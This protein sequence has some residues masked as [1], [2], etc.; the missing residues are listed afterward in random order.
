ML[1]CGSTHLTNLKKICSRQKHAIRIVFNKTKFKHI[2]ELFKLINV[3][4]LHKFINIYKYIN[5]LRN[6]VFMHRVNTETSPTV[7][8]RRVQKIYHLYSTTRFFFQY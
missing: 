2:K 1:L 5:I 3:L 4:N 8:T 6:V 7:F